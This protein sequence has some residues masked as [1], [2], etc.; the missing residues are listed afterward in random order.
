MNAIKTYEARLIEF[1][2]LSSEINRLIHGGA[3]MDPALFAR[4]ERARIELAAARRE[5][6][7]E[8]GVASVHKQ[9]NEKNR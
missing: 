4:E 8:W 6:F 5:A 1:E 9:R 3:A 2:A 7:A